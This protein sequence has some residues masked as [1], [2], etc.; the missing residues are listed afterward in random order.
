VLLVGAFKAG[1]GMTFVVE[2][3]V[4]AEPT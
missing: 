3:G 2:Q 4:E 1:H